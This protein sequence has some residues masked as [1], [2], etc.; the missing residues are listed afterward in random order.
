MNEYIKKSEESITSY[1]IR[2]YKNRKNYGLTFKEIGKLLN[3]VTGNNYSEAKYRR[4]IQHYLEIQ[5]YLEQENPT[6]V[7]SD[8]LEEIE[9]EKIELQKQ[10]VRMRDQK[11]ELNAII[12]RQARLESLEDYFKEV[13]ENFE[14]VSL[15]KT[16]SN[17]NDKK[18]AAIVISDWHI[19]MKFDGR[20]N[21]FNHEVAEQRIAKV[22]DKTL[23]TVRKENIDTL[24]IAN[25]GDMISGS[26]HVSTRIQAEED[27]IQQVIRASEYLKQFIKTFLDEGIQVEYY[28]VIGNHGRSQSNKS[29]V[30]GI[31][32]NFEKLIL[33]ILDT[34]FSS[35]SNY[36]STG[37]RD[38][39]IEVEISNQK[40]IL[41]HGEMDKNTNAAMRLPQLFAYVPNYIITGHIHHSTSKD[42]GVTEH[43]VNPSLIG[44]DDYA[45]A[46]RFG[47]KPGQKLILF[48]ETDIESITTI[49][50]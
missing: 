22:K 42:F 25:L 36:N 48:N 5:E 24:H 20:F 39:I 37:C 40:I 43:I 3:E 21:I 15:P 1:S 6:G 11:R 45:T 27:V 4:Q 31:E 46:G 34:A 9:L 16:K 50:F 29:E 2:L 12:R 26:I 7:D 41:A 28:N 47:G 10:Q 23:D 19:G 35:Y 8:V 33:T 13:T 32:E 14:G 49:K 17:V 38:G 18:E 30:A 44:A